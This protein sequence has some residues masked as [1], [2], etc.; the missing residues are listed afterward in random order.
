MQNCKL[1]REIKT[2]DWE[3]RYVLD[4][5]G[6]EGEGEGEEEEEGEGRGGEE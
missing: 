3:A 4:C 6:I 1:E 2:A 5:S